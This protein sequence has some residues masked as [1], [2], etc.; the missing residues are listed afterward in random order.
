MTV[1]GEEAF[2]VEE[3]AMLAEG[4]AGTAFAI[5]PPQFDITKARVLLGWS[6]RHH[7][8]A[9]FR[10]RPAQAVPARRARPVW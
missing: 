10:R 8:S 1:A 3:L 5:D 2:A 7:V 6:P 4:G 9:A